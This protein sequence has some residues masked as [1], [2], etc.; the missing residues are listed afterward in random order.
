MD[1]SVK[2][3]VYDREKNSDEHSEPSVG[4]FSTL[5]FF[6][7]LGSDESMVTNGNGK[8]NDGKSSLPPLKVAKK[9]VSGGGDDSFEF[10][11]LDEI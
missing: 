7:S 10:Y 5:S 6:E 4:F 11:N 1:R 8:K 3:M 2:T 9:D